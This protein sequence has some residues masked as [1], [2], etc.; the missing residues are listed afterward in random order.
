MLL[1]P[2]ICHWAKLSVLAIIKTY[3]CQTPVNLKIMLIWVNIVQEHRHKNFLISLK[4]SEPIYFLDSSN[5]LDPSL[6]LFCSSNGKQ[7]EVN[8]VVHLSAIPLPPPHHFL[9]W[10]PRVVEFS[11][12]QIWPKSWLDLH[13]GLGFRLGGKQRITWS[14]LM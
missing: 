6:C 7:I 11:I 13:H 3:F 2:W 10:I 5:H 4:D 12:D 9:R 1:R 14:N 8:H